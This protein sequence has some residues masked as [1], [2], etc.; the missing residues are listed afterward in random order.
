[1]TLYLKYRPQKIAE[2]DLK[3]VRE[4]LEA[5]VKSGRDLPH[6]WLFSG[7]RGTGKTSTA[8]ILAKYVNCRGKDKPCNKCETCVSIT[9]GSCPD[10]IEIDAASN[11][12]IDEIRQLRER[13]GLAPMTTDYKVYIIDEAHML[14]TEAANA[15]LKTLEEPP[16][17]VLF[18]LCTTESEK[19]PETV[20]SRCAVVRFGRPS[21]DEISDR[22]EKVAKSEKVKLDLGDIKEIA[23]A[24]RG[25]FRDAVKLFEQVM[26]GEGDVKKMLGA[27]DKSDPQ[28][29]L[30]MVRAGKTKEALGRVDELVQGGVDLR[31][32]VEK[33]VELLR[34]ELIGSVTNEKTANSGELIKL[35]EGLEKAY[36]RMKDAAVV[37]LPI[38]IFVIENSKAPVGFE[39]QSRPSNGQAPNAKQPPSSIEQKIKPQISG[40]VTGG[41]KLDDVMGKWQEVIKAVRP[42]NHSVEALLRSTRP[43]DFDGRDLVLEAFYEF[44]KKQL[45]TERCRLIVEEAVGEI[46]GVGQVKL[47]MKLGNSPVR[48]QK[49]TDDLKS[50]ELIETAREIFK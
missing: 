41:S 11:R 35:I 29:F 48:V 8:R 20:V 49:V 17:H 39:P 37:Q 25:S 23:A 28:E 1:M 4:R 33:C 9:N 38:E 24:A 36:G 7:P 14:T 18:V 34:E 46:L 31:K 6:A 42:K 50:D 40:L 32:F 2:L 43:V 44:H 22:L 3:S 12:G 19:L 13:V 45:E 26:L 30:G 10:V 15:L 47:K 21:I 16:E 5:M 27:S